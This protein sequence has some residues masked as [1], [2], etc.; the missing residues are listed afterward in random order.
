[1]DDRVPLRDGYTRRGRCQHWRHLLRRSPLY[2]P[3]DIRLAGDVLTSLDANQ[4]KQIWVSV[5][6][7][8]DTVP[9]IYRGHID[10]QEHNQRSVQRLDLQ[11]EVLPIKILEADQDLF[12]WL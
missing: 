12:I 6:V 2:Q 1:K 11:V 8:G 4:S 5:H 10:L 9:G 7:P 3:P